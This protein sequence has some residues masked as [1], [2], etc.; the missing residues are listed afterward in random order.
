MK[1]WEEIVPEPET[2]NSLNNN[3]C[4]H[5]DFYKDSPIL[6]KL[7]CIARENKIYFVANFG[8]KQPCKR[9]STVTLSRNS[10]NVHTIQSDKCPSDNYFQYN[11]DVI[12]S[13]NGTLL[14]RYRKF[15]IFIEPF[16]KAPSVEHVTLDTPFGKLGIITC[17]D[18][19]FKNPAI[20]LVEK[21]LV[22]T[23]LFPTWW[24]DALPSLSA[25]QY[26]DA[27]S[28]AM[29][30]NLLAAN[31]HQ[32]R[33]GSLGSGIYSGAGGAQIYVGQGNNK[34]KLMLASIPKRAGKKHP[35]KKQI[36]ASS[37]CKSNYKP[38]MFNIEVQGLKED[39]SQ[40]KHAD[41][42][43]EPGKDIILPLVWFSDTLSECI[44]GFCCKLTYS[45]SGNN[46]KISQYID[47]LVL[48]VRNGLRPGKFSWWEQT[49]S[50]ATLDHPNE[51]GHN[52]TKNIGISAND[53]L[54]ALEGLF[55]FE[56]LELTANFAT[57]YVYPIAAHNISRL[58]PEEMRQMS[59]RKQKKDT[60]DENECTFSYNG[61][62]DKDSEPLLVASMYARVYDKDEMIP[63]SNGK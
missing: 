20:D 13:P 9:A 36:E 3:P 2:L 24:F 1:S 60:G 40:Y 4:M 28:K 39:T 35:W 43:I 18:M 17:F 26:Q 27:W 62:N 11:T 58:V 63:R 45:L 6:T 37:R 44:D 54:F 29:G 47:K 25:I 14:K 51:D 7:S 30:V 10:E 34:S 15:N 12:F 59:C 33:K 32:A 48:V 23:I 38:R 42:I 49:C 52:V 50:L 46:H 41:E 5:T 31:L 19:M 56:H 22:D 55:S 8:S 21:N 57:D 53:Y 61:G 16:D